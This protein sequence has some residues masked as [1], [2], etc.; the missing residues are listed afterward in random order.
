MQSRSVTTSRQK[1]QRTDL[2]LPLVTISSEITV[3][4]TGSRATTIR[5]KLYNVKGRRVAEPVV[6][7]LPPKGAFRAP[8]TALFT[9][10]DWSSV[11]HA[12]ISSGMPAVA[13]AEVRDFRVAPSLSLVNAVS[14]P[15]GP[16]HFGFPACSTGSSW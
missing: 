10:F 1:R 5:I 11:T 16:I 3:V 12:K 7:V 15:S 13:A 8:A 4:N 14:V 6:R 2:I 9:P